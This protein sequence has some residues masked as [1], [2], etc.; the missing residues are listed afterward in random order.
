MPKPISSSQ[1][2]PVPDEVLHHLAKFAKVP[3]DDRQLFFDNVCEA[4]QTAWERHDI[5]KG[6]P[7]KK[8]I[9]ALE[10]TAAILYRTIRNLNKPE[11][12][13]IEKIV[14]ERKFALNRIS[15]K[16]GLLEA[17]YQV[18]HLFSIL[19]GK[20]P[21]PYPRRAGQPARRGKP[22]GSVTNWIYQD[23]V[24]DLILVARAAGG[25]LPVNPKLRKGPLII[26]IE[27][28][29]PHLPDALIRKPLSAE[30]LRRINKSVSATEKQANEQD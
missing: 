11:R 6:L 21:P 20:P 28:L 7:I 10:K 9:K 23:F 4:V 12:E 26:A 25:R 15:R 19:T 3:P 29:A 27:L 30:T 13:F 2:A 16:E 18:S 24:F 17:A 14:A 8:K 1:Q 22:P 5:M